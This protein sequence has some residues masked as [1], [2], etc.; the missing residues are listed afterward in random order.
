MR[1]PWL[2]TLIIVHQNKNLS[3]VLS[4]SVRMPD[5]YRSQNSH[6]VSERSQY[7]NNKTCLV[8]VGCMNRSWHNYIILNFLLGLPKE[9]NDETESFFRHGEFLFYN[10]VF[11]IDINIIYIFLTHLVKVVKQILH[12]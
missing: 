10:T 1:T 3:I 12:I 5:L 7:I 8:L 2:F 9:K 11:G 4:K 6:I